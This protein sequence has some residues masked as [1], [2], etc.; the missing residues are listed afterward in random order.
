[1]FRGYCDAIPNTPKGYDR[2]FAVMDSEHQSRT[3]RGPVQADVYRYTSLNLTGASESDEF[4]WLSLEQ[5]CMAYAHGKSAGTTTLNYYVSKSG[6]SY[7]PVKSTGES[8]PRKIKFL[9]ILDRLQHL[10]AGLEEDVSPNL[11]SLSLRFSGLTLVDRI[12]TR[13]IDI[14]TAHSLKIPSATVTTLIWISNNR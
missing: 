8:K 14:S 6:S 13:C 7:P 9:Q 4:P 12:R 5:P 1:M 11:T 2:F 10:E 3:D